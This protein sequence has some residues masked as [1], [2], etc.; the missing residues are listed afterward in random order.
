[1]TFYLSMHDTRARALLASLLACL[2]MPTYAV[3]DGC[4][5]WKWNK[6]ADIHEP[7]QK[8]IIL[9]D[10]GR[11]DMILQVKYQG[12]VTDFGWLIPV[13][14]KPEV[15]KVSMD[16][17]YELSRIVQIRSSDLFDGRKEQEEG[18]RVLEYKTVGVYEIA[19]LTATDAKA[20]K[21]WLKDNEFNWPD[22]GDQVLQA[23]IGNNWY[24]V[25]ARISVDKATESGVQTKL[26][27]GELHPLKISFDTN[28]CVYPLAISSLNKNDTLIHIYMISHD[29]P[30][31][32]SDMDFLTPQGAPFSNRFRDTA[33]TFEKKS[34]I[35][36]DLPRLS[37]KSWHLVKHAQ[38]FKP[39]EMHDLTFLPANEKNLTD[40]C[41]KYLRHWV[42][43][44]DLSRPKRITPEAGYYAV[45]A[46]YH[47]PKAFETIA[48]K[49]IKNSTPNQLGWIARINWEVA[50]T[51]PDIISSLLAHKWL[52]AIG[53]SNYD[54]RIQYGHLLSGMKHHAV[55]GVRLLVDEGANY[56]KQ[57]R[58][59]HPSF[60]TSLGNMLRHCPDEQSIAKLIKLF[61]DVHEPGAPEPA[62]TNTKSHLITALAETHSTAAVDVLIE[63]L[64]TAPGLIAR[65][66][67]KTGNKRSPGAL[68][69]A[70]LIRGWAKGC[71]FLPMLSK[72]DR[73][74]AFECIIKSID[75]EPKDGVVGGEHLGNFVR[76]G[77]TKKQEK[78]LCARAFKLHRSSNTDPVFRK[79]IEHLYE[80]SLKEKDTEKVQALLETAVRARNCLTKG[81]DTEPGD[82]L[83][84]KMALRAY[85]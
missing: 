65:A 75:A 9:Y 13:P 56:N 60:D 47:A 23:Y 7:S 3:A 34:A 22:K 19:T 14:G 76:K 28:E 24:F 82:A 77:L 63:Y 40:A 62:Y 70:L 46:A 20:L 37:E 36:K 30:W 12:S 55:T 18:V 39:S 69:K 35:L 43:T 58:C 64:E 80:E 72:L 31:I 21:K 78:A 16:S 33:I 53:G 59:L 49:L 26:R 8:A 71:H 54:R 38:L 66:L 51:E 32:C 83:I 48:E 85:E 84:A 57:T 61:R 1:M 67:V 27:T 45:V 10:R 68:A 73:N 5:V 15:T 6:G 29:R 74:A 25:A 44:H 79:R 42:D 41:E 17:F 50:A 81:K 2:M 4:F 52:A 11:E